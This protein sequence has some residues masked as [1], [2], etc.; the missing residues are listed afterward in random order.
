MQ[1]ILTTEEVAALLKCSTRTVE[2]HARSGR[3]PG[4]KFGEGWVFAADLV[5]EAVKRIS[6]EA[7]ESRSKPPTKKNAVQFA[8]NATAKSRRIPGLSLLPQ[9][10]VDKLMA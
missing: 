2:D 9:D 4:A 7:A 6:L 5:V 3:I 10:V 8:H 1:P